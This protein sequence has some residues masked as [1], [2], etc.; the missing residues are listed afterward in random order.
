MRH[1]LQS[2]VAKHWPKLVLGGHVSYLGSAFLEGHGM[3]SVLAGLLGI[4]LVSG[5]IFHLEGE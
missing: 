3:Y 4:M 1:F 5:S 2:H